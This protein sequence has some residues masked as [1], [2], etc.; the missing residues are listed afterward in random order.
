VSAVK[1]VID[2]FLASCLIKGHKHAVKAVKAVVGLVAHCAAGHHL[3]TRHAA[4]L[5]VF[6]IVF[7]DVAD[8]TVRTLPVS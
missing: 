7:P 1:A 2:S 5:L 8:F 4:T 6:R 3:F